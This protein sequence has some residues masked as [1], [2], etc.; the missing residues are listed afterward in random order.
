MAIH[1]TAIIGPKAQ[2]DSDVEIG[3]NVIV[4][5]DA[6]IEGGTEIMANAY[7]AQGTRIGKDNKIHMG[8][9]IG[10]LPQD[11]AF[12][13]SQ[14]SYVKI[15]RGNTIREYVTIHRGTKKDTDTVIGNDCFLMATSHVAHNCV[16][17]DHAVLANGVLLAGY[18]FVGEKAFISGLVAIHQFVRIGAYVI[19]SGHS[20]VN[21]DIP[22]FMLA[23]G[24]PCAVSAVNLVGL[25]RGG[26]A[27]F[28]IEKIK[29]YY[30]MI[31][32][33]GLNTSQALDALKKEEPNENLERI[34]GFMESS[35]RGLCIG[36]GIK[37]R[38]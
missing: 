34:I 19:I 6:V 25:R 22:P 18:V 7:V 13:K 31:F 32:K 29:A 4:E 27:R 17:E 5:D 14:K 36:S 23:G 9:V 28:D 15:G 10:N 26:F 35:Q 37:D 33:S 1:K 12:D 21:K 24:R 8:A 20:A 38:S 11:M 3:P 16:L 2:I 30:K